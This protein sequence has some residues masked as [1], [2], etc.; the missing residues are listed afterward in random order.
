[1]SMNLWW[2][3]LQKSTVFHVL[4]NGSNHMQGQFLFKQKIEQ[5]SNVEEET[6][7]KEK[8]MKIYHFFGV[9]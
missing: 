4:L 8:L 5:C 3:L 6:Y 9:V 2:A 1:M 7:L